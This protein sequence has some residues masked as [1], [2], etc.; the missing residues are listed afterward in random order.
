MFHVWTKHT[1]VTG[2]QLPALPK[3]QGGKV[4]RVVEPHP[5]MSPPHQKASV[6]GKSVA[7]SAL[8][9]M[10]KPYVF[11]EAGCGRGFSKSKDLQII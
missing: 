4:M 5:I 10:D 9:T 11:Q 6:P 2:R 3:V 7:C 1:R 8:P